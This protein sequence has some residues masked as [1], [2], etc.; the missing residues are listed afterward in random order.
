[1]EAG[2][3]DF[4]TKPLDHELLRVRLSVAERIQHM[5]EQ[6]RALASVL[7]IC[8]HC[9]SVRDGGHDWRRMEEYFHDVDFSHGYCPTCYYE[10]SLMPEMERLHAERKV[11]KLEGE[12]TL[13]VTVLRELLDF[14]EHD[15]P[16]LFDELCDGLYAEETATRADFEA[17]LQSGVLPPDALVRLAQVR[18]RAADLGLGRLERA[19]GQVV[20]QPEAELLD[21]HAERGQML[22]EELHA[23]LVALHE[24]QSARKQDRKQDRKQGR[25]PAAGKPAASTP[26]GETEPPN[27]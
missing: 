8:M 6:V 13:D 24:A 18:R 19:L 3:D 20:L 2:V 22:T 10:H 9:K 25:K 16:G 1:M 21:G 15:S 23:A 4:L 26:V 12:R 14:E 17:Y 27:A 11:P 7:P 5:G